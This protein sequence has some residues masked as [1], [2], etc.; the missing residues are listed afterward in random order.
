MNALQLVKKESSYEE[1]AAALF[2]D[3]CERNKD[4]LFI[5]SSELGMLI[6]PDFFKQF[7]KTEEKFLSWIDV[8]SAVKDSALKGNFEIHNISS[9]FTQPVLC[10]SF[11]RQNQEQNQGGQSAKEVS[12]Q[13]GSLI[14]VR[15]NKEV[16]PNYK[17]YNRYRV[18]YQ[19][20]TQMSSYGYASDVAIVRLSSRKF[21]FSS[22]CVFICS[23]VSNAPQPKRNRCE[24]WSAR[25]VL[26]AAG[27]PSGF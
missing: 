7:T 21:F 5:Y 10:I 19:P 12:E 26:P 2:G 18:N 11:S 9:F 8:N 14:S 24:T 4:T 27:V 22:S 6:Q 15:L 16:P 23:T 20:Q 3:F 17:G 1:K 13:F 25:T